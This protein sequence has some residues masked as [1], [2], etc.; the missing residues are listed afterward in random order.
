MSN[1]IVVPSKKSDIKNLLLKDI[2]G[3]II[4]I[5]DLS[6]YELELSID[7]V[8]DI[9]NNTD[10]EIFIAINKMIHN[11][12]LSLVREVLTKVKNSK[13]K[14]VMAYDLGVFNLAKKL[15]IKKELIISQEHLNASSGSNNFYYENGIEDALITSDLT[16]DEIK[17]IK[18]NTK[19][20]IYYTVY[21]YLPIFYSR[22]LVLTNYFKYINKDMKSD[23][24]YIYNNN[25]KYMIIEHNYGTIIYSP[26]VNLQNKMKDITKI[27]NPIIDLSY[28][29]DIEVLDKFI[30]NELANDEYTGFFDKKTIYKL[31]DDNNE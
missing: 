5:K 6:I 2:K 14:K 26:L 18:E 12:D 23:R 22:R 21:G 28:T 3:L 17:K 20:T 13:I 15:D 10:K 7:E 8:I 25:L 24:Y 11:S 29:S 30:N 16:I 1:L 4:G 31:K 19:N 9:A 27:I